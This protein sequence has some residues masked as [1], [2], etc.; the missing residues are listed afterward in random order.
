MTDFYDLRDNDKFFEAN[1]FWYFKIL[2]LQTITPV[3]TS[4]FVDFCFK[5]NPDK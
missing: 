1:T 4:I 3:F 5:K 2:Y